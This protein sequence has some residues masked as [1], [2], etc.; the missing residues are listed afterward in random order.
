MCADAAGC[1]AHCPTIT[2]D[3]T[4]DDRASSSA[5]FGERRVRERRGDARH[6][7]RS[8]RQGDRAIR[9]LALGPPHA[10]LPTQ[11][12]TQAPMASHRSSRI[13]RTA[14]PGRSNHLLLHHHETDN[15]GRQPPVSRERVLQKKTPH[16]IARHQRR[17][18]CIRAGRRISV[19]V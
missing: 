19:E 4:P 7:S 13:T 10:C 3:S 6:H 17:W 15:P 2:N 12:A 9:P 18:H 8:G 16:L 11:H 5:D 14:T 1:D